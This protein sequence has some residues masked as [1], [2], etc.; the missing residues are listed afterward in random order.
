[1]N[2]DSARGKRNASWVVFFGSFFLG[3]GFGGGVG[4]G[5]FI[6]AGGWCGFCGESRPAARGD[7]RSGEKCLR[8]RKIAGKKTASTGVSSP[9]WTPWN[10]FAGALENAFVPKGDKG[11]S[12][13]EARFPDRALSEEDPCI[14]WST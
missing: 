11:G 14:S 9:R 8:P 7:L 5:G 10:S 6:V 12:I 2:V 13:V 3:G 4:W 1:M